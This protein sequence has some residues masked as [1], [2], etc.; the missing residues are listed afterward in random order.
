MPIHYLPY[1]NINKTQWDACISDAGNGLIY[2][3]SYYLDA[4]AMQWDALVLNDYEAVM[5]LTY[6]KKFGIHYLYQ[7]YFT[8][9]LGV[10]GNNITAT[11]LLNFL[12]AVPSKFR[13]WDIYL[14]HSNHFILQGFNLYERM[15][16]VLPLTDGYETISKNF[17]DNVRRNIKKAAQLHCYSKKDITISEVIALA[18]EQAKNFSPIGE[19]AYKRFGHLYQ[20][21]IKRNE[22]V[23]YG[24]YSA[25]NQLLASA[26]FFFS[27]KRAYYILVGNHPNGKTIGASHALINA[28]I[29]DYAAQGLLLDFEGSDISSLAF[30]YSSFGALEEKYVGLKN[31]KLPKLIQFLKP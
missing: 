12:Q 19:D 1:K 16:Y 14:N 25:S 10:F 23:T 15:N 21:L 7:P 9:C 22:A 3:Y 8:A 30:F 26:V 18:K 31:N 6:N 29:Q 24:I 20:F 17:R 27:H 4:M 28:F 13:Y 5:P 11:V 2:G